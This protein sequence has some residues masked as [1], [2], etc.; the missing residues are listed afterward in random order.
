MKTI[1]EAISDGYDQLVIYW[2]EPTRHGTERTPLS[3]VSIGTPLATFASTFAENAG[4]ETVT[5]ASV[6]RPRKDLTAPMD[7]DELFLWGERSA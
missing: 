2:R 1:G 6:I 5:G 3:G 4:H 7:H